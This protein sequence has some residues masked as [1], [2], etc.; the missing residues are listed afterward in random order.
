M[1]RR[2]RRR[3]SQAKVEIV[4][5]ETQDEGEEGEGRRRIRQHALEAVFG[6]NGAEEE[7]SAE[8]RERTPGSN[9]IA[10]NNK[11]TANNGAR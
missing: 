4:N 3:V 7:K 6:V 9:K 1:H 8:L 5:E 10:S 11:D 2:V